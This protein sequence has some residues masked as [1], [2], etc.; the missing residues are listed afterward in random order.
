MTTPERFP[1]RLT[2]NDL[3]DLYDQH[4]P[5]GRRART[6]HF[7]QVARWVEAHPELVGY[8]AAGDFFYKLPA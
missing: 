6:L 4:N 2:W 5:G 1:Y 8:D 3:A 7:G